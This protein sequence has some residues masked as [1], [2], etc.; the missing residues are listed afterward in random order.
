MYNIDV[1]YKFILGSMFEETV[2]DDISRKVHEYTKAG[3]FFVSCSGE[4]LAFSAGKEEGG[5]Y[6]FDNGYLTFEGYEEFFGKM[7]S[8][9]RNKLIFPVSRPESAAGYVILTCVD[10]ENLTFFQELGR[11][12][13]EISQE[14][15]EE[16]KKNTLFQLP[17]KEQVICR[18]IFAENQCRNIS[19]DLVVSS[20][21]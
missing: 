5:K 15:F 14:F 18:T 21:L 8:D 3:V 17:L 12:L 2:L 6:S 13:A 9:E 19:A 16:K 4:L 7:P 11:V 1:C 20:N 10:K